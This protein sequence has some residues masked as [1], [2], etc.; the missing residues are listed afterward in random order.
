M[1]IEKQI[2]P[3][4][5]NYLGCRYSTWNGYEVCTQDID[6]LWALFPPVE[7]EDGEDFFEPLKEDISTNGL[8]HPIVVVPIT[9]ELTTR[10]EGRMSMW[11][12]EHP[13]NW[14]EDNTQLSVIVGNNRYEAAKQLGYKYI[15]CVLLD[16]DDLVGTAKLE[17]P[18]SWDKKE[19]SSVSESK[20]VL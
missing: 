3:I 17:Y 13:I 5:G 16:T 9:K 15:D 11:L 4:G 14:N 20:E 18:S 8:I 10:W 2:L 6:D 12:R 1:F 7:V 19:I